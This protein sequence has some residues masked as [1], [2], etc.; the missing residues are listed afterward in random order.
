MPVVT[1]SL[2]EV[3][4]DGYKSI[5]KG[6]RSRIVNKF[7]KEHSLK[8]SYKYVYDPN[9]MNDRF[10]VPI[11]LTALEVYQKQEHLERTLQTLWE[12]N[13]RLKEMVE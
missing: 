10:D 13:K 5:Q 2:C 8:N 9:K 11:K 12:E 6:N 7:L 3:G 4:Y 1:V